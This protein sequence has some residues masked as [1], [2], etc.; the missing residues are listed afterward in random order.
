M[1]ITVSKFPQV[2][3]LA[4]FRSSEVFP[5]FGSAVVWLQG[6][7]TPNDG[8]QSFYQVSLTDKT[9]ADNGTTCI[10]DL[11]G[12]R[13]FQVTTPEPPSGV[14]PVASGGTGDSTL[15]NH[16]VML[17]QGTSPVVVTAVGATG[18]VL[19]GVTGADPAFAAVNLTTDVTGTLPV[20]NGGTGA[21][22]LTSH[23][24]LIGNG[25]SAVSVTAAGTATTVLHGNASG[26]PTFGAVALTTDVSG[27]LPVANGGSG[28]TTA[29]AAYDAL[30][31]QGT[32]IASATTTDLSAATGAYVNITGS[33]TITGLG[34]ATAGTQRFVKFTGAPLLTYNATSL[35]LPGSANI[36][37]AAN[38]TAEFV[39]LGS[40][41]W[42]CTSYQK[43]TGY[44]VTSSRG[45]LPGTATNDS[46]S[47]GNVGEYVVSTIA[48]GSAVA[49]TTATAANITSIS[50][51]AG[52]WD[53][54][55]DCRIT[56]NAATTLS[57]VITSISTTS[58]TLDGTTAGRAAYGDF[59]TQAVFATLPAVSNNCG[60]T[61]VLLNATTTIYYVVTANFAVNTCSGYGSIFARR[62][63]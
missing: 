29:V 33:V 31:A 4:T 50:L 21:A 47:S 13:W 44:P 17:G 8:G 42:I 16:G 38:D 40:G 25:T 20:A 10:V 14:L 58:A 51:T 34:T 23:G 30:S 1:G 43:A 15:T 41:N 62:R 26:D 2:S 55:I 56:G 9:T 46:A 61:R 22:T 12:Y 48:F 63:R 35:I 5:A 19:K 52:D 6:T 57:S 36:Q 24:V 53:V 32:D 54:W 27:I 60:P 7:S 45:Q 39:S 3:D 11:G 28:K 37:A 18:T 49:L 59:Y